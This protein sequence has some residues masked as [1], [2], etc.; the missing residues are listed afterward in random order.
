MVHKGR[1]IYGI[2]AGDLGIFFTKKASA[3]NYLGFREGNSG[4][5]SGSR[6]LLHPTSPIP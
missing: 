6:I 2:V 3:F 5:Q 1:T 4:V